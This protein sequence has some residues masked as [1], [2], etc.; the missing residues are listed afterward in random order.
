LNK[1]W[2]ECSSLKKWV[3]GDFVCKK[4]CFK[5]KLASSTD[6]R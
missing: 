6:L 5:C 1:W 2:C 4:A 3:F